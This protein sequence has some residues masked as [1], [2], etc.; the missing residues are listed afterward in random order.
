MKILPRKSHDICH[1]YQYIVPFL[2]LYDYR[3]LDGGGGM[4]VADGTRVSFR[5]DFEEWDERGRKERGVRLLG[6]LVENYLCRL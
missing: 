4:D 6:V 2:L 5:G 3:K 1:F